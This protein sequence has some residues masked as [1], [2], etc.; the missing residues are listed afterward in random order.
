MTIRD[1]P[2][3]K[4]S[5]SKSEKEPVLSCESPTKFEMLRMS[6]TSLEMDKSDESYKKKYE[7]LQD[8]MKIH[9]TKRTGGNLSFSITNILQASSR[10]DRLKSNNNTS[11]TVATKYLQE[12]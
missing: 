4:M 2:F 8:V 5:K 11:L 3:Q 10:T 1:L 7:D 9:K 6:S 12:R